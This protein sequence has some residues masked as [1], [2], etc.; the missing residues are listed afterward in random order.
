M[1]NK[2]KLNW[3]KY[4]IG[5]SCNSDKQKIFDNNKEE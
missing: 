3:K 1:Y 5:L 4:L 2:K